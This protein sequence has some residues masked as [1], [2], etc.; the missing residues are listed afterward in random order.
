[1][2]NCS[3]RLSG[4]GRYD[5]VSPARRHL[6]IRESAGIAREFGGHSAL[7]ATISA[8]LTAERASQN[9]PR[10]TVLADYGDAS[11]TGG[12]WPQSRREDGYAILP[13]GPSDQKE[14][15]DSTD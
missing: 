11:R 10:P 2:A 4:T 15:G 3:A 5:R 14:V 6:C 1:M 12:G 7:Q 13:D 8:R 9:G